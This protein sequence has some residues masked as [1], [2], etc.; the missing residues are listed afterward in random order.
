MRPAW[1]RVRSL[2]DEE[3]KILAVDVSESPGEGFPVKGLQSTL[4]NLEHDRGYKGLFQG[5]SRDKCEREIRI[6]SASSSGS[7]SAA[8]AQLR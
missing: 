4:S 1:D 6:S 7:L 2:G 5:T 8:Q 3:Q